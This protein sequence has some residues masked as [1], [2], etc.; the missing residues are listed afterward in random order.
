MRIVAAAGTLV[1]L[2]S[3][4]IVGVAT[5][6]SAQTVG[7]HKIVQYSSKK[8]LTNAS[9]DKVVLKKCA[10]RPPKSQQWK[11][12]SKKFDHIRTAWLMKN[13]A[14]GR[15]LNSNGAGTVWTSR[16]NKNSEWQY[17][18]PTQ[19]GARMNWRTRLYLDTTSRGK[20]VA[21]K[22]DNRKK[23]QIWFNK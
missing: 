18:L 9:G 10:N 14:T 7:P 11:M 16:C 2:S 15:C 12:T 22:Y 1:L 17:W 20:V 6:A 3:A 21:K 8:C 5:S 19:M 13:Q 4:A 23:S